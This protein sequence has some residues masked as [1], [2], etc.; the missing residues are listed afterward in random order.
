[1]Q[2]KSFPQATHGQTDM[3]WKQQYNIKAVVENILGTMQL[4]KE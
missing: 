1:M 2:I 3:Q 4:K